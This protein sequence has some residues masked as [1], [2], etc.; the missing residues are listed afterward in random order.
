M[1]SKSGAMLALKARSARKS[2]GSVFCRFH[3]EASLYEL[4]VVQNP[5]YMAIQKYQTEFA[6]NLFGKY[7]CLLQQTDLDLLDQHG[8]FS[9]GNPCHIY[10]ICQRPRFTFTPSA[11]CVTRDGIVGELRVQVEN[12]SVLYPF[13]MDNRNVSTTLRQVA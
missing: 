10:M 8:N 7:S 3:L 9:E 11:F 1:A 2:R 13:V 6:L 4:V 12:D 5:R